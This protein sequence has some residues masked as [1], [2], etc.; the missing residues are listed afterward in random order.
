MKRR[1]ISFAPTG[2]T[3]LYFEKVEED[4]KTTLRSEQRATGNTPVLNKIISEY[5]FMKYGKEERIK[6]RN[7][8]YKDVIDKND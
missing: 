6:I 4:I 8:F 5:F 3:K 1:V 2:L 7:V